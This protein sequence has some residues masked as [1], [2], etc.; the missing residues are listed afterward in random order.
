[1]MMKKKKSRFWLFLFSLFPGAGH[2]YLGLMRMGLSF[3]FG[4]MLS[5]ALMN[6][7]GLDV[8]VVLPLTIYIYSFFHANNIGGMDDEAFA[9]LEDEY[10]LGFGDIDR[11]RFRLDR[12]NRNLAAVVLIILGICM[13]WNVGFGMI[14]D[15]IGWDNPVIKA[16][17]YTMRDDVPRVVIAIAIIWFGVVLLRGKKESNLVEDASRGQVKQIEEIVQTEQVNQTQQKED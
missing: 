13:L 8:L 3:M 6:I 16:I 9:A 2:M 10:L 17:Y 14:R 7:T 12:R 1:M 5:V 11:D 15:Y 4:F